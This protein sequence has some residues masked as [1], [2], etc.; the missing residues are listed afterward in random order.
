MFKLPFLFCVFALFFSFAQI[1]YADP[2]I[3]PNP[4]DIN[5]FILE[6]PAD[7]VES[8]TIQM[9]VISLRKVLLET[10]VPLLLIIAFA[11]F[12]YNVVRYFVGGA[13]NSENQEIARTYA[14]YSFAAFLFILIFW[15]IITF[16]IGALGFSTG[17][18]VNPDYLP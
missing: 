15:G 3:T 11:A 1:T 13:G 16:L 6:G 17:T 8:N 2:S 5:N 4:T 9:L 18:A 10:V 7:G 12:V 14:V